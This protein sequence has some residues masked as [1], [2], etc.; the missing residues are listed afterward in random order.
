MMA[1][2]ANDDEGVAFQASAFGVVSSWLLGGRR[3]A[4]AEDDDDRDVSAAASSRV[5]APV[6]LYRPSASAKPSLT[7]RSGPGAGGVGGNAAMVDADGRPVT[8]K[9]KELRKKLLRKSGS[10]AAAQ[11]VEAESAART[12]QQ[13]EQDKEEQALIES[14][15]K[16]TVTRDDSAASAAET[17]APTILTAA[18][19]ANLTKRKRN[20]Q[21]ELLESL[22]QDAARTRAKNQ[23]AK[24]RLQR[25]KAQER[26]TKL[27]S[28]T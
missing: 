27:A 19:N 16:Q 3:A 26:Q 15:T 4:D 5:R 8:E 22:R 12:Q 11:T 7:G 21:E 25:K 23:K 28:Q 9:E 24:Q 17:T 20:A 18:D 1:T 14:R 2:D 6:T 13:E 10:Y